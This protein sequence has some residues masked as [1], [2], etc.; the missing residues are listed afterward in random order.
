VRQALDRARLHRAEHEVA[1]VLQ[2]SLLPARLPALA[3]LAGAARYT[4]AAEHARS[5]GDWYDLI[6]VG[7]T[8]V[9]L[10]VGDVVGHG[11]AAAA[12][13]GQLRSALASQLLDGRSPAAALERLDRFAARVAGSAGSTCACMVL[14]WSTGELTWSLAGHP[15]VLLVD[16]VSARFL[17]GGAGAVLGVPGRAPYAEAATTVSAGASVVLYTDGLVERR[18]ETLDTGLDRLADA[19]ARRAEL[20]PEALAAG[21][22]GA[23]LDVEGPRDDVAL[24]V[25]RVVPAPLAGRL[26]AAATSMRA[27]RREVADWVG[28]AGLPVEV[29]EDLELALGEAAANAAEHAY[30]EGGGEFE[31]AVARTEDGSVEARVRDHGRW[32]PVP[33]DN[34]YR[35]HGLRVIRELGV[36]VRIDRGDAGTDV[37]FRIPA[38]R[39]GPDAAPLQRAI[40]GRPGERVTVQEWPGGLIVLRGDLDLAGREVV[41]PALRRAAGGPGPLVVDLTAV[42]YLS[43]AGVALL[44]ETA[45]T[46]VALSVVVAAGSAPAR[47]LEIAGLT[48]AL[49]VTVRDTGGAAAGA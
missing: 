3:R 43:S 45:A 19:A 24:L 15:P 7:G 34:G 18:G 29:A 46:G 41:A 49:P 12:V 28:A 8:R 4:P 27:L 47:V 40:R 10:V 16:D 5:G 1:D 25:V 26:P 20:G 9:A 42:R 44:A 22:V 11:P 21:L 35:G 30:P 48:S 23:V 14:D 13:M 2:R 32:R 6:P 31:Y 37:R 39:P 36:D 33:E 38:H 17:G